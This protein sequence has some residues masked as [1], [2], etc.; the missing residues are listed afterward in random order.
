MLPTQIN[1]HVHIR[2]RPNLLRQVYMV[3][4]ALFLLFVLIYYNQVNF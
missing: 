3:F 1:Q 2:I 4:I